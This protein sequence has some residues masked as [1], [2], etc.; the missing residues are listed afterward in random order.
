ME[1]AS[2]TNGRDDECIWNIGGKVRREEATTKT[3]T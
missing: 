3:K 1:R 2:S